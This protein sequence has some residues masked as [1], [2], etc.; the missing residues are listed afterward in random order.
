MSRQL[1]LLTRLCS[2]CLC[3]VGVAAYVVWNY[4]VSLKTC[5]LV[6]CPYFRQILTYFQNS[7]TGTF[8]G[9]FAKKWFVNIPPHLNSVATL[10][11]SHAER[12][13][14]V[15]NSIRQWYDTITWWW[16]VTAR[17][18][19]ISSLHCSSLYICSHGLTSATSC[20][21]TCSHKLMS[22]SQSAHVFSHQK[23]TVIVI[24][25]TM[26]MVQSFC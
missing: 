3:C 5:H 19:C 1:L 11:W 20:D 10:H 25:T 14:A 26:F 21:V 7:F 22:L 13:N 16:R 18:E 4:I 8:I 24:A 23:I 17:Y 15:T 2:C 6:Y 9:Q 12:W